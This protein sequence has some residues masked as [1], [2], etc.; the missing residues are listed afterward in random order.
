MSNKSC[1]EII[2]IRLLKALYL[3]IEINRRLKSNYSNILLYACCTEPSAQSAKV[4]LGDTLAALVKHYPALAKV[5]NENILPSEQAA[6]KA[7]QEISP[8]ELALQSELYKQ[9]GPGFAQTGSDIAAQTQ[10]GQVS[11]DLAASQGGGAELVKQLDAIQRGVD[12]EFYAT[13]EAAGGKVNALLAGQDP[14]SLT[15]AELANVE[16]GLNRSNISE[17]NL[18]PSAT[19][20]IKN[21]MTFGGALDKKRQNLADA[22][23]VATNFLSQSKS[24]INAFNVATGRGGPENQG[25]SKFNL[26]PNANAGQ[27]SNS[28]FSDVFGQT[29]AFELQKGQ[30]RA[31][32]ADTV[33]TVNSMVSSV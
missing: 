10:K 9:F 13:R 24:G 2:N 33:D 3:A 32:R 8:Q 30:I 27:D 17:G 5:A 28:M 26:T 23:N 1:D 16:R 4:Q 21:A 6:L 25:E 18:T 20:T 14:N 19:G 12:P 11:A 31:N 29:G 15:G 22:L 7:R